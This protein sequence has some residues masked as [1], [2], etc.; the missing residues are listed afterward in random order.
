[1]CSGKEESKRLG[2]QDGG[3]GDA[4][5]AHLIYGMVASGEPLDANFSVRGLAIQ[6][7]I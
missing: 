1:M 5:A 4:Q 2:I 3:G 7:G 6:D